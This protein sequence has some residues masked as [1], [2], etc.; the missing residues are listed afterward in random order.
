M[1]QVICF[2]IL[3]FSSLKIRDASANKGVLDLKAHLGD[4]TPVAMA[5][6]RITTVRAIGNL[7]FGRNMKSAM[8]PIGYLM[9]EVYYETVM[10]QVGGYNQRQNTG[11]GYNGGWPFFGE[12][13]YSGTYIYKGFWNRFPK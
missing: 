9:Q 8:P 4:I 3:L 5:D 6:G 13:E 1:F 10:R 11:N 12:H 7:A 2:W